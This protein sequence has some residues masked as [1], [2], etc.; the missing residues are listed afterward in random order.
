MKLLCNSAIFSSQVLSALLVLTL[1]GSCNQKT[2]LSKAKS[3]ETTG[4]VGSNDAV[5]SDWAKV[6][7]PYDISLGQQDRI[8]IKSTTGKGLEDDG[9]IYWPAPPKQLLPFPKSRRNTVFYYHLDRTEKTPNRGPVYSPIESVDL[10][11]GVLSVNDFRWNNWSVC[12]EEVMNVMEKKYG[13]YT[14]YFG[15][16]AGMKSN[17]ADSSTGQFGAP[18]ESAHAT[19]RSYN[20]NHNHV[21]FDKKAWDKPL[22]TEFMGLLENCAVPKEI[23]DELINAFPQ[24]GQESLNRPRM[25]E[26][27]SSEDFVQ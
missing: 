25:D 8:K 5:Q 4:D 21:R 27:Q 22:F 20:T 3:Q 11:N 26:A 17:K 16:E 6:T 9:F 24:E 14:E 2:G 12:W 10:T 13:N 7:S 19:K 15:T 18:H 1:L 23:G